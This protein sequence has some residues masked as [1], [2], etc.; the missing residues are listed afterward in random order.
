MRGI[1]DT[2]TD[3]RLAVQSMGEQAGLAYSMM[4]DGGYS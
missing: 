2:A 1:A 3:Q 4:T